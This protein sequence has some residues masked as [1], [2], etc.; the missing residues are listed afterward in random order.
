MIQLLN[1][2]GQ[3]YLLLGEDDH[4][5]IM[6]EKCG[7]GV[8]IDVRYNRT[9]EPNEVTG[10]E[11]SKLLPPGAKQHHVLSETENYYIDI[12]SE[13]SV[14]LPHCDEEEIVLPDG[15]LLFGD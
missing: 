8:A 7:T 12:K 2:N 11:I 3:P 10:W 4:V 5:V 9:E 6:A 14:V 15:E 1:V 13:L